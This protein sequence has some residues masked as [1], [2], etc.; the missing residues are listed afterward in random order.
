M[1]TT[2]DKAGRVVV[3][4]E[5]RRRFGLGPGT[6]IEISVD[7]SGIRIVKAVP[8]PVVERREGR[9]VARPRVAE[10]KRTEVDISRIL[11]EERERWPL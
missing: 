5:I 4:A 11:D 9:L 2:I 7:A 3:P 8:P 6:E 10:E 1:L